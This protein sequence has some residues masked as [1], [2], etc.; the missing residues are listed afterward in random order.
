[1]R[2][3]CYLLLISL[4]ISLSNASI[5]EETCKNISCSHPNIAYDFC[6]N[7][8]ESYND[9]LLVPDQRTLAVIATHLA[10]TTAV[11]TVVRIQELM[12]EEKNQPR[13]N[14]LD[15]CMEEYSNAINE[16]TTAAQALNVCRDSDA[17]TFLSAAL[18][19]ASNCEDAFAEAEDPSPLEEEDGEYGE[20]AAIA[21]AIVAALR[22]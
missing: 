4:F 9:S 10:N 2:A 3:F 21:L 15:T 19:A 11:K 16:L 8:F 1:M 12:Q 22:R 17:Q 20:L 5:V 13:R 18:D 14:R 6:I 7:S